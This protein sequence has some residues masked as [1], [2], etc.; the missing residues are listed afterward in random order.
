MGLLSIQLRGIIWLKCLLV[1]QCQKKS[2]DP[3]SPVHLVCKQVVLIMRGWPHLPKLGEACWPSQLSG[4]RAFQ[5]FGSRTSTKQNLVS[6]STLLHVV[7][8]ANM[9]T[10]T[11]EPLCCFRA[12]FS[13]GVIANVLEKRS[14]KVSINL[15]SSSKKRH[16]SYTGSTSNQ[17]PLQGT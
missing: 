11:G 17:H 1:E 15:F 12:V 5:M 16:P 8:L 4:P 10:K 7:K 13:E 9:P 6:A 3:T 2:P 14:F